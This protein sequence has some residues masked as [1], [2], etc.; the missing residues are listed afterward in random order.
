MA[1]TTHKETKVAD[2]KVGDSSET[3]GPAYV[4]PEHAESDNTSLESGPGFDQSATKKLL[5]KLDWHL[6]PFLALLYL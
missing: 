2:E 4:K 1:T 3:D 5:R 6:V